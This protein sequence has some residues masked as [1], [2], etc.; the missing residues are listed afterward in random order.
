MP[1]GRIQEKK[2]LGQNSN[3]KSNASQVTGSTL[4]CHPRITESKEQATQFGLEGKWRR[5]HWSRFGQS[6]VAGVTASNCPMNEAG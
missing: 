5:M 3:W 6:K 1:F 2:M 4:L